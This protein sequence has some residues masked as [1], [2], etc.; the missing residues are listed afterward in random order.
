MRIAVTGRRGQALGALSE[1]GAPDFEI[2]ALGRLARGLVDRHGVVGAALRPVN[3][4][5]DT[6][7]FALVYGFFRPEWT[8]STPARVERLLDAPL[9]SES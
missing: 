9:G 8:R 4:R 3:L 7:K 2:V 6:T 1:R 5:L